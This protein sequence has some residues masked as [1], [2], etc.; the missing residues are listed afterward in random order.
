MPVSEYRPA[1][2]WETLLSSQ[3]D[4]SG[5]AYPDFPVAFNRALYE[6]MRRAVTGLV[7]EG[8]IDLRGADVLEIGPGTGFWVDLWQE[9]GA[10]SVTGLDI[11]DTAVAQLSGR[12]PDQQ[13][14]TGDVS[15]EGL[16]LGRFDVVSAQSVLLHIVDEG[17]LATALRNIATMLKP[18]GSFLL[19]E[20]LVE[21]AWW[22]PPVTATS[23]SR[24]RTVAQWRAALAGVG[25]ELVTY[26]PVTALLANV[27]DTRH[28]A[29]WRLHMTYW[30]LVRRW[31][32]RVPRL[33]PATLRLLVALDGLL[34]RLGVAPSAKVMLVRHQA[35]R[36]SA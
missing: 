12:F 15:D 19:M 21:H 28:R 5:V 20:P 34:L 27:C 1:D 29:T 7:A 31:L 32:T 35:A 9:F 17:P 18:D 11:T 8:G 16:D 24:A 6:Q 26:R 36:E 14:R 22:G 25:L 10:A 30:W 23:N 3:Y 2:Y 13:F 4:L 33:A